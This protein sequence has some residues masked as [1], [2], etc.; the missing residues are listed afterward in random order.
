MQNAS[1]DLFSR[2]SALSS[3]WYTKSVIVTLIPIQRQSSF[4]YITHFKHKGNSKC[5]N[6]EEEQLIRKR[7]VENEWD[8]VDESRQT[9]NAN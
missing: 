1:T 6:V 7:V 8:K 3:G 9:M 5:D 4:I 2:A